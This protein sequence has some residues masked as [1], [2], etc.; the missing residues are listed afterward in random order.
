M[1]GL[2]LIDKGKETAQGDLECIDKENRK[3]GNGKDFPLSRGEPETWKT[4]E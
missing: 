2:T 1:G 4:E 3:Q